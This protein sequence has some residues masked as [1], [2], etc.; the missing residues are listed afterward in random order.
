MKGCKTSRT[1]GCGHSALRGAASSD[2]LEVAGKARYKRLAHYLSA[3]EKLGLSEF[4]KNHPDGF[5]I[6]KFHSTLDK[7]VMFQ[8]STQQIDNDDTLK[9]LEKTHLQAYVLDARVI[10][11]KKR[12][13]K[14]FDNVITIGRS[15]DN[16]IV[17]Y[18][19]YVS[20][21]HACLRKFPE[22]ETIYL[23]DLDSKNFTFLN[24]VKLT[25][26]EMYKL[27]VEDEISFGIQTKVFYFSAS[28]FYNFL[29]ALKENSETAS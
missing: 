14:E 21:S 13:S 22:D 12:K 11:L 6:E 23:I 10:K 2:G 18:N 7:N 24:N 8:F 19:R 25:P 29:V 17:L 3:I 15:P 1:S 26:K 16:A 27:T 9:Q 28:E 20:K 4:K 5:F